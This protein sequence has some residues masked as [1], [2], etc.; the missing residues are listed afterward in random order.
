[1]RR[2]VFLSFLSKKQ[3]VQFRGFG[4]DRMSGFFSNSSLKM[5]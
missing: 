4:L 1:L 5:V 3:A 2:N